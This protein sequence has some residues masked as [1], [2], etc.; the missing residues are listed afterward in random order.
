MNLQIESKM[1]YLV[2]NIKYKCG[3]IISPRQG[4][5]ISLYWNLWCFHIRPARQIFISGVFW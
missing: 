4:T 5:E 1:G 2:N 3:I